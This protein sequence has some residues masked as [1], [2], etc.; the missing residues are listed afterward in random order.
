M[1]STRTPQSAPAPHDEHMNN[2]V[3]IRYVP[4]QAVYFYFFPPT[5]QAEKLRE[6]ETERRGQAAA[7]TII[8]IKTVAPSPTFY[9]K[10]RSLRL[11][12]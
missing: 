6:S 9:P 2:I 12:P 4:L 7:T 11:R 5:F 10:Q 1:G 3:D 8:S